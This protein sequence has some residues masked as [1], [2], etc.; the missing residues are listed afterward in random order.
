M[1]NEGPKCIRCTN[2]LPEGARQGFCPLCKVELREKAARA[3]WKSNRHAWTVVQR[4]D[5]CEVTPVPLP[6][7]KCSAC[8]AVL[9]QKK[10]RPSP[11]GGWSWERR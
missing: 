8:L 2:R 1:R 9:G 5:R 4:C 11:L 10:K 6:G 3:D 7:D